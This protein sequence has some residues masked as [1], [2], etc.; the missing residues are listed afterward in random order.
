M[1]KAVTRRDQAQG[2]K[3]IT[4]ISDTEVQLAEQE[5][6]AAIE[7]CKPETL[8]QLSPL[9]QAVTLAKSMTTIREMMTLDFVEAVFMPLQG[10]VLGFTTDRDKRTDGPTSYPATVVRDVMIEGMMKGLRPINNEIIVISSKCYAGKNGLTRQV[11]EFPGLSDLQVEISVPVSGNDG[12][13]IAAR[14]FWKLN[15]QPM[16]LRRELETVVDE[17]GNKRVFD[18]RIA[19]KI[20]KAMGI[21]ALQGKAKRKL[22]AQIYERL[23][24]IEIPTEDDVLEVDGVAVPDGTKNEPKTDPRPKP[25]TSRRKASLSGNAPKS[26]AKPEPVE[27]PSSELEKVTWNEVGEVIEGEVVEDDGSQPSLVS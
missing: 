27:E 5:I 8:A 22:F 13:L 11:S 14:A 9:S 20:N 3:A 25:P 23:C 2:Q 10:S 6:N 21:D 17:H 7:A 4:R 19:V 1:T 24:G 18:N 16:E 26:E 12:A 15:G